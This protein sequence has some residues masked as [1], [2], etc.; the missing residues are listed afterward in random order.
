[1]RL[2]IYNRQATN[3]AARRLLAIARA[4][5]IPVLGVTATKPA[6]TTY[7]VGCRLPLAGPVGP[8][9]PRLVA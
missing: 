6:N 1:M 3:D 2:L 7:Q 8:G 5:G 4:A 9:G